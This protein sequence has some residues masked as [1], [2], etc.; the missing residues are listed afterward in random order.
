M[1]K[2][3][4]AIILAFLLSIYI[5]IPCGAAGATISIGSV[6]AVPGET[7][8]VPV[9]ISGNPGI[10]TFSLGFSYDTNTLTLLDVKLSSNL[11][12]Q[13]AYKKKAVWLNSSDTK[14]NGDI[15][16]LTFKVSDIAEYGDSSIS[17]TYAPGDISNYNE[18]DVNFAVSP[19]SVSI[20]I[21]QQTVNTI[22]TIL[23]RLME[24]LRRLLQ[25][26]RA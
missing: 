14:Y 11:G 16:Y 4:S 6:E 18:D 23:K 2:K 15:L 20:G 19:G 9:S 25:I 5:V 24:I 7:V 8:T 21:D 1:L 22:K 17:V 12:G 10:N 3:T 26:F 13:F